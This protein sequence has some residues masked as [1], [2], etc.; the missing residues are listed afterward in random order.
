M[1]YLLII[2]DLR[3]PC[4]Y[5]SLS[6]NAGV[7]R[8][9]DIFISYAR[10]DRAPIEKLAQALEQ[11]EGLTNALLDEREQRER[12][13]VSELCGRLAVLMCGRVAVN[14]ACVYQA[15]FEAEK[16]ATATLA[17]D[18]RETIYQVADPLNAALAKK[19]GVKTQLY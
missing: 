8:V 19:A 17:A 11:L 12:L 18:L 1:V 3:H 14:C 10:P 2:M 13:T 16:D 7:P 15:E 9:A 5:S 6:Q 4:P